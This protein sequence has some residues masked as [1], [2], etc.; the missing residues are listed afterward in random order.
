ML[1]SNFKNIKLIFRATKD[2]F[3]NIITPVGKSLTVIQSKDP[4]KIFGC[5]YSIQK[6]KFGN[7]LIDHEQ[8]FLF[9]VRNEDSIVRLSCSKKYRFR[10]FLS[11]GDGDL[12]LS[13]NCNNSFDSYSKL[14][15]S[16][17]MP[18]GILKDS[19]QANTYLAG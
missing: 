8:S 1:T 15:S 11:F 3:E 5:F 14:G 13:K 18:H 7:Y 2:G 19:E 12:V 17:D 16:F 10:R 6:S 9:S 4:Q